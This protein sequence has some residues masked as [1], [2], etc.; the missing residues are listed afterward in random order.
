MPISSRRS[1]QIIPYGW[2]EAYTMYWKLLSHG[3]MCHVVWLRTK[4]VAIAIPK[5][6]VRKSRGR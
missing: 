1:M 3:V 4:E 2:I 6:Q 5:N